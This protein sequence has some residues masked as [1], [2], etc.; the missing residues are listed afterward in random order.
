VNG[1]FQDG[2]RLRL[3]FLKGVCENGL[4]QDGNR[5]RLGFLKGVCENLGTSEKECSE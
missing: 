3:G 5:L 4:F 2:N 1:L